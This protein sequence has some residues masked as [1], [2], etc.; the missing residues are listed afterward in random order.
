MIFNKCIILKINVAVEKEDLG[1]N[2]YY[3]CYNYR[4]SKNVLMGS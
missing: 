4:V 1:I 2:T 3:E